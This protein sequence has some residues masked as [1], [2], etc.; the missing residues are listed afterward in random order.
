MDIASLRN[1]MAGA[2]FFGAAVAA[3]AWIAS[4]EAAYLDDA[5]RL[6]IGDERPF[7]NGEEGR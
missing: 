1:V 5:A 4:D 3:Y 6:P 2:L 7:G